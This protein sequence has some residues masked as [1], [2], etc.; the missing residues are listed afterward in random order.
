MCGK[1]SMLEKGWSHF[2]P[3]EEEYKERYRAYTKHAVKMWSDKA[4]P[5]SEAETWYSLHRNEICLEML[6]D[7]CK[8]KKVLDMACCHWPEH[9]LLAALQADA[10][11]ID[12]AGSLCGDDVLEMDAC[13]TSFDDE[14]FDVIICREVIEHVI[15]DTKLFNEIHRLVRKGGY[16][17]ISTPN[18][19]NYPPNGLDHIRAFTPGGF[20]QMLEHLGFRIVT[21]RG[22][23]PNMPY[24]FA[25]A[26][27]G[28]KWI[29]P[30]FQKIAQHLRGKDSYYFGTCLYVLAQKKEDGNEG[31]M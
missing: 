23:V 7:L 30:E 15:S 18:A 24:F 12:I 8:D 16:L 11:K 13:D 19:F 2:P 4:R 20:L 22:D 6:G 17:F 1:D 31:I 26:R 28:N 3:S 10:T 27:A 21:K 14:S 9:E 25:L 5:A 29:L